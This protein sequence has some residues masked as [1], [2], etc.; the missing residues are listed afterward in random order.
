MISR[1]EGFDAPEAG[2]FE[3]AREHDMAIDPVLSND[4]RGKA[5]PHL[6]RDP[7]LLREHGDGP[8]FPRA[9]Q[10]LLEDRADG[11]RLSLKVGSKRGATAGMRLIPV[12][13]LAA[14]VRTTPHD[15]WIVRSVARCF[16][17]RLR[18]HLLS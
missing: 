15:R 3:P 16:I 1:G 5:H 9:A 18:R 14:A 10:Q 2:I 4:E 6:K 7:G 11:R 8:V 17:L 12:R 13:K